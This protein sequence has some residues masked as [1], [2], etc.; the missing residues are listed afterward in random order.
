MESNRIVFLRAL[1]KGITVLL[2]YFVGYF[3]VSSNLDE[4][5]AMWPVAGAIAI[6]ITVSDYLRNRVK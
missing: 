1:V 3:L 4:T 6:V 2:F 5:L